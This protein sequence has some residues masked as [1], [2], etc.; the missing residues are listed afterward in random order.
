MKLSDVGPK[1]CRVCLKRS[2]KLRSLYKPLDEGEEPPVEMLRLITGVT[3]EEAYNFE[4]LPKCICKNCE[5]SLSLAYQFRA[6]VLRTHNIIETYRKQVLNTNELNSYENQTSSVKVE[7]EGLTN[8]EFYVSEE[9]IKNN[10]EMKVEVLELSFSDLDDDDILGNEQMQESNEGDVINEE[11]KP[12]YLDDVEFYN[13]ENIPS[14]QRVDTQS[15]AEE[16]HEE[17]VNFFSYNTVDVES[18]SESIEDVSMEEETSSIQRLDEASGAEEN[19]MP[20]LHDTIVGECRKHMKQKSSTKVIVH[21]KEKQKGIMV[22]TNLDAPKKTYKKTDRSGSNT[23]HICDICGNIYAKRGRMM[24]HRRRHDKELRFSCELCDKRF[25]LREKLRK[26]MFLHTGGKPYKCSF[27]SRTFFYESVKKAHEA[28]HSGAKPYVCDE[29]NKAFAYAHALSKHKLIHADI[30]L[31]HCEYC[32]KD[33]RLQH[34]MK[35]HIETKLHQNAV[36]VA[37][38]AQS[39][40]KTLVPSPT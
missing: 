14:V 11:C 15:P 30:K 23:A 8:E 27:C 39:D 12:E 13:D 24:E 2:P 33:F 36:R 6:K 10:K 4:T 9:N 25:H 19:Q 31:Y 7:L 16:Q 5:L 20:E 26:H 28:V 22:E 1:S 40:R 38:M 29:C 35:Q 18:D 21:N 37:Q 3:L 32:N 17:R 34:H